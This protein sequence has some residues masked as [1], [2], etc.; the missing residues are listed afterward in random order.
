M[1]AKAPKEVKHL[2]PA[3][4]QEI[5]DVLSQHGTPTEALADLNK[6][7]AKKGIRELEKSAVHRSVRGETRKIGAAETRG[8]KN[9]LT[10]SDI[11]KLLL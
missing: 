4:Q 9:T 6:A 7:R 5:R 11:K 1:P 3:E 10:N 8:R 2:T